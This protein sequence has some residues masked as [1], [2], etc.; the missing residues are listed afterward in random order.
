MSFE[1][2]KEEG[3]RNFKEGSY[4]VAAELYQKCVDI[5]PENPIGYSNKAMALIKLGRYTEVVELCRKGLTFTPNT[6]D[7]VYK[8]LNYRLE[9]ALKNMKHVND[10][11]QSNEH[12]IN[13]EINEVDRLPEE[14][15]NL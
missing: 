3:N 12:L 11:E 10:Q 7:T 2:Y 14:F 6:T 8:K 5:E 4:K 1:Q 15:I 9:M 13:I